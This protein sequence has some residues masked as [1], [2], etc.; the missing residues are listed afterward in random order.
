MAIGADPIASTLRAPSLDDE[1]SAA[2][3]W[4]NAAQLHQLFA[5]LPAVVII[6]DRDGIYRF[7]GGRDLAIPTDHPAESIGRSVFEDRR[8]RP[9]ILADIRRALTGETIQSTR[10]TCDHVWETQYAPLR[11]AAGAVI[12]VIYIALD[13]TAR[14]QAQAALRESESRLR[15]QYQAFPL[16]TYTWQRRDGGFV[17]V[18]RN[19]AADLTSGGRIE[20]HLGQA[21]SIL[22][23]DFPLVREHLSRCYA[24]Q[25]TLQHELQFGGRALIVSYVY[26]APDLVVMHSEDITERR[27]AELAQQRSEADFRTLV[28]QVPV[29]IYRAP[30]DGTGA[31]LFINSQATAA[32]GYAPE[33][34]TTDPNFWLDRLHPDDRPAILAAFAEGRATDQ[35]VRVDYR[36]RAADGREVWIHDDA[37]LIRDNAGQLLYWQGLMRDIT[38][39]KRTD[40][41]LANQATILELIAQDAPLAETLTL[42]ARAVEAVGD[43]TLV[44]ILLVEE[45]G[46][47]LDCV[48][49]PSIPATFIDA[50]R[51]LPIAEGIGACGTAAFR[52]TP[53]VAA[54]TATDPYWA[55][56]RDLALGHGL[57]SCWSIPI[58]SYVGCPDDSTGQL[59]GTF[60]VYSHTPR[61]PT[62]ADWQILERSVGLAATAIERA[63]A[64]ASLR[65]SAESFNSLFDA[66]NEGLILHENGPILAA[67]STYAAMLGYE[68]EEVIG[69]RGLD[70]LTPE[71]RAL[72]EERSV[73]GDERP[74]EA[75]LIRKD[76]STFPAE[77]AGKAIRYHGRPARIVTVRDI[78]ARK[79]AEEALRNSEERLAA[80]QELA[81]LGSWEEDLSSGRISWSD[82]AFR[83]CGYA[84][85]SFTPTPA[86]LMAAL[87]PDD[88]AMLSRTRRDAVERGSGGELHFRV[89]RP[90]G[91]IRI[92]QQQS[93]VILDE[94]G[95]SIKRRGVIID[96]TERRALEE[97]LAH[98]A[99]HDALTGLPNRALLLDR[100][101]QTFARTRRG[102][103]ACAVFFLDLDNFK[104]VND[105]LGHE[106]GDRL[107]VTL[108]RRLRAVL[109]DADTLA[110]LGGDE[111]AVLLDEAADAAAAAEVAQRLAQAI[112]A[113]VPIEGQTY[114]ITA[115]IGI[116][117]ST[118]DH[119]R[120]DDLLRDADIA[121]Y[122]AKSEGK[123]GYALFDPAMQAEIVAR[124][125]LER[126]LRGALERNEFHLHYQPLISLTTGRVSEVEALLRWRHPERGA[127][128]ADVFIPVAEESGLITPLGRWVLREACRQARIWV[129]QGS[130]LTV[131]INLSARE[132]QQADL[133]EVVAAALAECSLSPEFLRLEITERLAMRDAN[134]TI[135]TLA[136]LRALG[137]H[138]AIDDFGTGYS[139]LAYLRRFPVDALKI[140]RSFI[141]GLG[142]NA[143]DSAIV[144]AIAGLGRTLGLAVIAEG[145]ETATQ[146]AHLR[147]LSCPLAQGYYF[148]RPMGA[149]ALGERLLADAEPVLP[150]AVPLQ[151]PTTGEFRQR[152]AAR[153][154]AALL[155]TT[156]GREL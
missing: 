105:S 67:N 124:L 16:P 102:G 41:L 39:R 59:L 84:P 146:V 34:W 117:L 112:E 55:D 123:A 43:G 115:S 27:R 53:V 100:L 33:D 121:M 139:S 134:A 1:G 107:L 57:R 61:Q 110:R 129:D 60:A 4:A 96:V 31:T 44:S 92:V 17:F 9:D 64:A 154:R 149:A 132:F 153:S 13:N 14:A 156:V 26:V 19:A 51:H 136:A 120:P 62:A 155:P 127:V 93:E 78:T 68:V 46:A 85:Q 141:A 69:R 88:R 5:T 104:L 20:G 70:F 58:L 130:P 21:A 72:G 49:A 54:D 79:A 106:A 87:H 150:P 3:P 47:T 76:G 144:E 28:E 82:E 98:Q 42:L 140:D 10:A 142:T 99:T 48:A 86:H 81:H 114:R 71:T 8:D 23:R 108:A 50:T 97:R 95:R 143:E 111:F 89:V 126:D 148:A 38:E 65:Q 91:E 12:G 24:E 118:P 131:A 94:A 29:M 113:P 151:K 101:G 122:R 6:V 90:D 145:A 30:A 35:P 116:V 80:A 45:G 7:V 32:L 147:A 83:I 56:Y 63:R 137:V 103:A 109:R 133:A 77:L 74:Y 73:A 25:T 15:A 2:L 37:T 22:Y 66:T 135:A 152:R 11:D 36:F 138:L 128:P 119:E 75:V 125:A 52:R 18:D 40:A